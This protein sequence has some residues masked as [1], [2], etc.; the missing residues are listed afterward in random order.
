MSLQKNPLWRPVDLQ[1]DRGRGRVGA[2]KSLRIP[3]RV[4]VGISHISDFSGEKR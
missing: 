4:G 1:K 2:A 3:R